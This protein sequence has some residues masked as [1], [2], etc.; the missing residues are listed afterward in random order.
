MAYIK[1]V[2]YIE[3][4]RIIFAWKLHN[5]HHSH[6]RSI[7]SD[8]V[9]SSECFG[10]WKHYVLRFAF[11]IECLVHGRC[12]WTYRQ[13]GSTLPLRCVHPV[14][15]STSR[16]IRGQFLGWHKHRF[17]ECGRSILPMNNEINIQ[18][19]W[20]I[21]GNRRNL[22]DS[23]WNWIAE[24]TGARVDCWNFC[25]VFFIYPL[26]P[27][28]FAEDHGLPVSRVEKPVRQIWL[29]HLLHWITSSSKT[30]PF[31]FVSRIW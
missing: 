10:C 30:L 5:Q 11:F 21:W 2:Y 16:C 25:S 20:F 18:T 29:V 7:F 17:K 12:E 22:Q 27:R 23:Y 24:Y 14:Y 19:W 13:K 26:P 3:K 31:T 9:F 15:S 8:L 4:I 6:T 28:F 1:I